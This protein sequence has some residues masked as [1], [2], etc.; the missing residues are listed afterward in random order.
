ME[1]DAPVA[2]VEAKPRDTV[3]GGA[4]HDPE[5]LARERGPCRGIRNAEA[6]V[7]QRR[8]AHDFPP[9]AKRARS[10]PPAPACPN[11]LTPRPPSKL[12]TAPV[13][14]AASVRLAKKTYAHAYSS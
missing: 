4:L 1:S 12:R 8:N 14:G 11:P 10:A 5:S 7:A 3:A 2:R 6:D 13:A 9:S